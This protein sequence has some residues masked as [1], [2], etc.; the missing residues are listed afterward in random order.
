[1]PP[2][3][4]SDELAEARHEISKLKDVVEKQ[5]KA[6]EMYKEHAHDVEKALLRVKYDDGEKLP[7][8]GPA[9]LLLFQCATSN[10]I[11]LG[12][13]GKRIDHSSIYLA[14]NVIYVKTVE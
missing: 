11:C 1:M 7:L 14:D 12:P 3:C 4:F 9:L 6:I 13:N 5:K 10:Q 2:T 8:P